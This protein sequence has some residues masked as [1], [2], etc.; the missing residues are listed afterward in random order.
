[1]I[2]TIKISTIPSF[3]QDIDLLSTAQAAYAPLDFVE[4]VAIP[5]ATSHDTLV[6][7]DCAFL[8]EFLPQRAMIVLIFWYSGS[9][10]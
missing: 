5:Q 2:L 7:A 9:L 1:M 6:K 10:P 4:R 3:L 8:G